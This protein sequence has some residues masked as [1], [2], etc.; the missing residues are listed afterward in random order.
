MGFW[1]FMFIM[2]LLVPF[3]L[4]FIWYVCPKIKKVNGITGYRTSRSVKNQSTWDF[5]QRV[6][7]RNSMK[8]FFPTTILAVVIMPFCQNKDNNTIGWIGLGVTLTQLISYG[9]ILSLTEKDLKKE[10]DDRGKRRASA[11]DSNI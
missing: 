5:A 7:A 2:T 11:P 1:I 9:I 10:F 6:C 3:S 8:M 4:I